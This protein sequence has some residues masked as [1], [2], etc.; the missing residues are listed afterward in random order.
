M[1]PPPLQTAAPSYHIGSTHASTNQGPSSSPG[2]LGG[3]Q[4]NQVPTPSPGFLG[5]GQAGNQFC[6]LFLYLPRYV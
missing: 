3:G 6:S 2:F 1:A 5:G 4:A